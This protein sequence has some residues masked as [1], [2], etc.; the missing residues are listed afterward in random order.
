M[1]SLRGKSFVNGQ[2]RAEPCT[3]SSFPL[4]GSVLEKQNGPQPGYLAYAEC[5]GVGQAQAL[6]PVFV[7]T[8]AVN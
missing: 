6:K 5:F 3:C 1:G 7:Q 4:R 8:G 2:G